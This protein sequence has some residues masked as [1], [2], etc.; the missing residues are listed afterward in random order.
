M[1]QAV[2]FVKGTIEFFTLLFSYATGNYIAGQVL[3]YIAAGAFF[4]AVGGFVQGL[5]KVP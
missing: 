5:Y 4:N 1:G 3:G 2:A